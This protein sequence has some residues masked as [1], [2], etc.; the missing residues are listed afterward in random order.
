MKQDYKTSQI[1]LTNV[2]MLLFILSFTIKGQN[3]LSGAESV[4]YDA[5]HDRYLVSSYYNGKIVSVDTS[6][7]QTPFI[8]G[9]G[10]CLGNVLHNEVLYVSCG[11]KVRGISTDSA[12]IVFDISIPNTTNL[13]GMTVDSSGYLYVIETIAGRLYKIDLQTEESTMFVPYG[14]GDSPQDLIFDKKNN[15]ILCCSWS[16]N[17][18]VKAVDLADGR[19]YT[20][21]T[22]STGYFDGITMDD[23]GNIY[24]ASHVGNGGVYMKDKSLQNPEILIAEGMSEPAGLDYDPV[25][26][27]LAVP[28]FSGNKVHFI[29][30][31]QITSVEENGIL[32]ESIEL[33]NNFP[34]PFNPGTNISFTLNAADAVKLNI[35]DINGR[36]VKKLVSGELNGGFHR[37]YWDGTNELNNQVSSG[38]YIFTLETNGISLSKEMML[39][40]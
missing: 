12:K 23:E 20:A 8:E 17:S 18:P 31:D 10:R 29:Y 1:F 28:A 33:H 21:F 27:L 11:S 22:T 36:L 2:L 16:Y 3:Y 13:D 15:R 5:E 24:L 9:L 6:G 30:L 14:L 4:A 19:T 32:P 7:E 35:Y 26:N 34:N 25:N 39:L 40:K 38:V 37:F